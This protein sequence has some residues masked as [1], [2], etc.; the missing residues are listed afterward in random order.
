MSKRKDT[1]PPKQNELTLERKLDV[2]KDIS[3]KMTVRQIAAKYGVSV[4]T[5]T[6]IK[7]A[8]K[9]LGVTWSHNAKAWMTSAIYTE[10]AEDLNKRMKKEKRKRI[11]L[12][13]NASSHQNCQGS[14]PEA[15]CKFCCF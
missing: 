8:K 10:W 6:D 3:D 14:L 15:T 2:L 11:V 7:K 4:G 9:R 1:E 5:V 12:L 13:D